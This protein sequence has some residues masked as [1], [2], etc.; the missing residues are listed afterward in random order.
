[1]VCA[2]IGALPRQLTWGLIAGELPGQLV[3][4]CCECA[5]VCVLQVVLPA[6]DLGCGLLPQEGCGQQ[7][8]QAGE[9]IAGGE[10]PALANEL[11]EKLPDAS[12]LGTPPLLFFSI[13]TLLLFCTSQPAGA[14]VKE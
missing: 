6:A 1:M 7:G 4:T 9:H 12:A 13:A 8:H 2:D 11:L 14:A 3:L 10:C 5:C